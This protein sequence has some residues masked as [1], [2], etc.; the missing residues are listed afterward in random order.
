MN[1]ILV[2]MCK[3]FLRENYHQVQCVI[4]YLYLTVYYLNGFIFCFNYVYQL[5]GLC[6]VSIMIITNI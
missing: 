4:D 5:T 3:Y 1:D 2:F 6:V